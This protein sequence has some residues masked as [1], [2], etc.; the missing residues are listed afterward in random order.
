MGELSPARPLSVGEWNFLAGEGT[1]G[2]ALAGLGI[3]FVYCDHGAIRG[4]EWHE[5]TH[6]YNQ[7][8]P[9]GDDVWAIERPA[10]YVEDEDCL[11][12][13]SDPVVV[14]DAVYPSVSS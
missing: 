14:A 2:A 4:D 5:H 11:L 12:I 6:Q 7:L 13:L 10:N 1:L 3:R 8:G 9:D